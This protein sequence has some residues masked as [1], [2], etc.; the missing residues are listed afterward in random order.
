MFKRSLNCYGIQVNM[1]KLDDIDDPEDL[2]EEDLI[3]SFSN[4]TLGTNET[5]DNGWLKMWNNRIRLF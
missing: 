2:I 1:G 5:Q 3:K 4:L